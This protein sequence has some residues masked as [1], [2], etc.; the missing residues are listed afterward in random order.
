M[1]MIM[2]LEHEHE[3]AYD[4]DL[5]VDHKR[6]NKHTIHITTGKTVEKQAITLKKTRLQ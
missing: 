3:H 2:S 6:I 5:G 4:S 1:I